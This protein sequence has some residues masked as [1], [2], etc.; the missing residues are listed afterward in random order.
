LI[1]Q[2][3]PVPYQWPGQP[4]D[5]AFPPAKAD[6][7]ANSPT[8]GW[9]CGDHGSPIWEPINFYHNTVVMKDPAFRNYY[10]Q[11]WGGHTAKTTRRVF[12]NIFVQ[13]GG[14]P[15]LVFE[16]GGDDIQADGNLLWGVAGPTG[17]DGFAAYLQT[18]PLLADSKRAFAVARG[19]SDIA[20]HPDFVTLPDD[21]K[22]PADVRLQSGSPAIDAGI[23]IP[24]DWPDP[25][26]NRD[27]GEPDIGALPLGADTLRV[28]VDGK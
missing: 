8:S 10:G 19:A 2:R 22:E 6:E 7:G 14:N 26:R 28:G 12:N 5:P 17:E 18:A 15:G 23:P 27:R 1:D 4:D 9:L 16:N 3:S 11:G 20:D 25:L 24:A 21:W 13:M